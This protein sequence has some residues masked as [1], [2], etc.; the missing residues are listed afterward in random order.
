[1][2]SMGVESAY[3][4]HESRIGQPSGNVTADQLAATVGRVARSWTW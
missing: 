1:M 2:R 3:G 4:V